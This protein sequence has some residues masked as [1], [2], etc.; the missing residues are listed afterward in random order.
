MTPR[1]GVPIESRL[2]LLP[3]LVMKDP[4]C[5]VGLG[6][7]LLHHGLRTRVV[8]L[9]NGVAVQWEGTY[10]LADVRLRNLRGC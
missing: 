9:L 2:R 3:F 10:Q 4:N 7:L 1:S 5:S 6:E 8:C